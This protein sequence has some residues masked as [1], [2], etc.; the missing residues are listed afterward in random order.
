MVLGRTA[1]DLLSLLESGRLAP[2]VGAAVHAR[3]VEEGDAFH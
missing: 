2:Q 3:N 1:G